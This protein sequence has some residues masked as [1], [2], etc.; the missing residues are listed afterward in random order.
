MNKTR[1]LTL[2]FVLALSGFSSAY[3]Q[4]PALA[5]GTYKLA[6]SSRTPCDVTVS[7]DGSFT[8]AAD[9]ATGANITKWAA[10]GTSGYQLLTASGEVYAV[11][12]QHGEA[13]EGTTFADQHKIVLSH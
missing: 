9:C 1:F 8:P 4:A 7:A 10:S 13:L 2:S 3:A 11:L 12:K 5:S 6:I